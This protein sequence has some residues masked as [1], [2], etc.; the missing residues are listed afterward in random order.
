VGKS[1][2]DIGSGNIFG[3]NLSL[4]RKLACII[5]FSY[6]FIILPSASLR[7]PISLRNRIYDTFLIFEKEN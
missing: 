7:N 1:F 2:F 4:K 5:Y 3:G 6:I